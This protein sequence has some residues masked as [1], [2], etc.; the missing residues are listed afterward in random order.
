[1]PAAPE[2]LALR[3]L[4]RLA[5]GVFFYPRLFVYPQLLLIAVCLFYTVDKLQLNTSRDALVGARK[6]YHQ[7]FLRYKQEFPLQDDLV[8]AVESEDME[9]N[10]QFVERLGRRLE[11]ETNLFTDVFYKGDLKLLG[12]KALL[13]LDEDSLNELQ[14]TL[15]DFGPF[16]QRFSATTNLASLFDMVNRQFRTAKREANEENNALIQGLPALERLL[17][18]ADACLHSRHT[19]VSPGINA[20]F[21]AGPEAEQQ[22]YVTFANGRLY[23][24]TA[25]AL[26]EDL[27][28][29]AV[30]RLRELVS[31]TQAEAP[32]VNVGITGEP[33]LELDE[34]AQS[35]KD[36][37]VATVVSLVLVALIFI[38]GY[39][40][41]GRPIKATVCL[42]VGLIYTLGFAT[43]AVGHL[44][45]LT[46]TFLPML[47]G[48][49]IDFG[50]HL[51][52]RYEEELGLGRT[53]HQALEK[54]MVFTGLGIFT[55]C[56]TTA[57]AFLA[58]GVTNFKGIQEMGVI[59]GGGLLI[60]LLP[61]MTLLPILLLRGRQNLIDRERAGLGE[62]RARLE[63]LWLQR[64]RWTIGLTC[65][66]CLLALLGAPRVYFDYNLLH[67]QS[68]G[69]P[70]VK[71]EEKLINSATNSVL[72]AAIVADN[73]QQA[74]A[75]EAQ[76]TNLSTVANVKSMS[77]FMGGDPTRRLATIG[78]IKRDLADVCFSP[79][80]L[81]PV[82]LARLD[83]TLYSL[84]GYLGAAAEDRKKAG[85]KKLED[86]LR[87]MHAAVVQL[88]VDCRKG[89]PAE[90]QRQLTGFEGALFSDIQETFEALK[91]Q[92]NSGPL[93]SQDLPLALKDRFVGRTG[94]FLLQVYP[95]EDVWQ[96]ENQRAFVQQLRKVDPNV[97]GTPIQLYEYTGLLKRSYEQAAWYALGAIVVLV[98]LHFHS[99]LCVLLALLPVGIGTL[100][101]VGLMGAFKVPFNPA[102]I[103][104]LPLVIGVGVTSGIHIL[105]RFAEEQK[106]S[107]LA[108]STGLAVFISALTTIAGF[109]SLMLA[110]HRGISSLGFVMAV[111]TTTCM[112]AALTF[113]PAV[114]TLLTRWGW[115][116]KKPSAENAHPAPGRE[117]PRHKP[118][119]ISAPGLDG[120]A[121]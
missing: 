10:R 89:D 86:A 69:L 64:P 7:N 110:K 60:C 11:A 80:D 18:E 43:L 78:E 27:N 114:I 34:M 13:F 103:M 65:A 100:W 71:V 105:N 79:R 83:A 102:N 107:I 24:V 36:T 53:P 121:A 8:V 117:E 50:V 62:R 66:V 109:G 19:P 84:Q 16:I 17:A 35:E 85:D 98:F 90:V 59:S 93:R 4:R 88:R 32:G 33:V 106:P 67:M 119:S 113:L 6:A 72:F 54:A 108:R 101:M 96:R 48:M 56:F 15:H 39:Q 52:S 12:R 95:K 40:E 26:R 51:I 81:S 116:I 28:G 42:I 49:G 111:G 61:M 5:H 46:I 87:A 20:L 22:M 104:T 30:K 63:Q 120:K 74:Q 58:M 99:L 97:T 37:T 82:N 21:N 70:A 76:I 38:Y 45:L 94:K 115:T 41:S 9:K 1:M 55:G 2:W 44:N 91:N 68:A 23:L 57:G 31:Q 73:L 77:T 25:H 75:L 3:V 92:D 47:I 112:V 14:K 29:S 118:Q